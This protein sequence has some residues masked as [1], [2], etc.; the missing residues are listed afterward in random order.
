M[1]VRR[2][3]QGR[4]AAPCVIASRALAP[5]RH[6]EARSA[7]AI[8]VPVLRPMDCFVPRNDGIGMR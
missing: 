5:F 4:S 6:C 7:V 8:H 3:S 2:S 1:E